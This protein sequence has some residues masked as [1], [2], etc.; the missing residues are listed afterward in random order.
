VVDNYTVLQDLWD[1]C[2]PRD[3]ETKARVHGVSAQMKSFEY[4]FGVMLA[5]EVLRLT[6]N[7]SKALQ[8]A[9]LSASEGQ[10]L[11]K[12]TLDTL[13]E[14]R[15]DDGYSVFWDKVNSV[16]QS[17]DVSEPVIPRKR[18]MPR[19][20]QLG[21]SD[22]S[23]PVT[24]ED[25]FRPRY[26]EAV[27]LVMASVRERF[28][29]PGYR[30]L[31]N[32]EDLLIKSAQ[33]EQQ[34]RSVELDAVCEFYSSDLDKDRLNV[35]LDMLRTHFK[36]S[37]HTTV[38]LS[39]IFSYLRQLAIPA[40]ELFSEVVTLVRI[41]LVI[42]ATNATSERSFSALRRIKTY[43]RSTMTQERLN[44]LMVLHIHKN[45]TDALDLKQVANEFSVSRERRRCVFGSFE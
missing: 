29:Q 5:H 26:F 41:L 35:Q 24:V 18:K 28:D 11:A 37:D 33:P 40:R 45:R 44:N 20:Y 38:V 15:S 21:T 31:R 6:D 42:P 34:E 36:T 14:M 12:L 23:H 27:D 13:E 1:E 7:L 8:Q 16:S 19:R 32:V 4:L 43:L 3:S 9:S 22:G 2:D 39:D 30:V 25:V 10:R 17:L